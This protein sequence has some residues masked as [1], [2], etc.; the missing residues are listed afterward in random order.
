MTRINVVHPSEL[1]D[2]HLLAEY[3]ELPRVF[4]L[5]RHGASVPAEYVLGAGHVTFFYD[6]LGFLACRFNEL[7]LEAQRRG[8]NVTIPLD[9]MWHNAVKAGGRVPTELFGSYTPTPAAIA[10]NR[11]RIKDRMPPKPRFTKGENNVTKA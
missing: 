10:L 1:C 4:S 3:R 5:A 6:K 11:Q 8:F 9:A 7:V 2:Q